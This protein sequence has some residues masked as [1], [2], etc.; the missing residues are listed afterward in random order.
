[1]YNAKTK[2]EFSRK[3]ND[4]DISG[5]DNL[6]LFILSCICCFC[7]RRL[8]LLFMKITPSDISKVA[9]VVKLNCPVE[10]N[11]LLLPSEKMNLQ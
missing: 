9:A 5:N 6:C 11:T 10:K 4:D 2:S 7:R 1:M 3:R 8:L